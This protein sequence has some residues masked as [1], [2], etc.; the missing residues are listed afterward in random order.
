MNATFNVQHLTLPVM[1][2]V[3]LLLAANPAHPAVL[4]IDATT[5][6]YPLGLYLEVLEDSQ[7]TLSFS[8]VVHSSGF[9]TNHIQNINHGFSSSS[10]WY[11]I[12]LKNSTEQ[13]LERLFELDDPLVNH[14]TL[15]I[16]KNNQLITRM[17]GGS[18]TAFPEKI[19]KARGQVFPIELPARETLTLYINAHGE[20]PLFLP[21]TLW[22]LEAWVSKV[23]VETSLFSLYFGILIA[24]VIYN[25]FVYLSVRDNVYLAYV[26][27]LVGSILY[28]ITTNGFLSEYLLPDNTALALTAAP[29]AVTIMTM[30]GISFSIMFLE[31]PPGN[32]FR[33]ALNF[34]WFIALLNPVLVLIDGP[35][36]GIMYGLPVGAG[37]CTLG[38]IVGYLEMIRGSR[39]AKFYCAAWTVFLLG[40]IVIML[41]NFGIL[42]KNSLTYHGVQAGSA[43]E[44]LLISFALAYKIKVLR[45]EKERAQEQAMVLERTAIANEY[46]AR[47]KEAEAKAKSEFLANM[48]HEI[49]TPMSGVLGVSQLMRDTPLNKQQSEF[50]D[51]IHS[52]GE[53]LL[54]IINDILDFSKIEAG[55]LEIESIDFDLPKLVG[56]IAKIFEVNGKLKEGVNFFWEIDEDIPKILKG[57][58]TRIRQVITNFLSNA[59]KFTS[60][61]AVCL[62]VRIDTDPD[63]H[64]QRVR[65]EVRDSGIGLTE[66][67][68]EK[69][70]QSYSQADTSTSR[71]YGGTGL[72]LT[73]CKMLTNLMN[74]SIGVESN[75]GEGATFWFSIPLVKGNHPVVP[76]D[77]CLDSTPINVTKLYLLVAEDNPVNQLVITKLL[78]KLSIKYRLVENGEK[79][80]AYFKEEKFDVILMDCEMPGMDGYEATRAIR[81]YETNHQLP[82]TTII[83]L[84]ANVMREQV[85]KCKASG[86]NDHLGKPIS[87][88]CLTNALAKV[89]ESPKTQAL[90]LSRL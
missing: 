42:P 88:K 58:P 68:I 22:N 59:F 4:T 5:P 55:K 48:S 65:F 8:D 49:R 46:K 64:H 61:G 51:I 89:V 71:N 25:F 76:D 86:M 6:S 37:A 26:T 1:C 19:I 56:E 53:S 75:V 35:R 54:A 38:L 10:F 81:Q 31:L 15:Y 85:D 3:I 66:K 17:V 7:N 24:M 70:F 47:L 87:L 43:I 44:A 41:V 84:T 39:V 13:H 63:G 78:D 12:E 80:F 72:G 40:V 50:M 16:T 23:R 34:F 21:M 77:A 2:L 82:A 73:I 57:D 20:W 9:Q 90:N 83:A 33:R 67:N 27:F 69:I 36:W 60:E 52:S 45:N 74:G 18:L 32:I 30:F 14:V 79:A 28:F 11:R 29:F 62:Q